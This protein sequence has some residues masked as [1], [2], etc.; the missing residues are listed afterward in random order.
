MDEH[1]ALEKIKEAFARVGQGEWFCRA[2]V[3]FIGPMGKVEVTPG[4]SYRKGRLL[5]GLDVAEMLD[6]WHATGRL[7]PNISLK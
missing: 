1:A 3:T 4:V 6:A 7:P 5:S 2:P